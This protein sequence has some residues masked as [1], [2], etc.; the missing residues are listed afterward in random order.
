MIRLPLVFC[1]VQTCLFTPSPHAAESTALAKIAGRA[2]HR[3]VVFELNAN[4]P[5]QRRA[6]AN[7]IAIQTIER[8]GRIPIVT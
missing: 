1:L 2:R 6:L 7:A 5:T 3:V 4:N 8:D